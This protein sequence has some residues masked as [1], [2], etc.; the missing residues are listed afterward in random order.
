MAKLLKFPA[1]KRDKDHFAPLETLITL[2]GNKIIKKAAKEEA[3]SNTIG[4]R[5]DSLVAL[6]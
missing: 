3:H 4:V 1:P 6:K 5:A 2:Q